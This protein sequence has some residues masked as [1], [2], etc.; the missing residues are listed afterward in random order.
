MKSHL[1]FFTSSLGLLSVSWF[2]MAATIRQAAAIELDFM[3]TEEQ[4]TENSGTKINDTIDMFYNEEKDCQSGV[5]R[6]NKNYT[7]IGSENYSQKN[8]WLKFYVGFDVNWYVKR[9]GGNIS[10]LLRNAPTIHS[11]NFW[12]RWQDFDLYG[13]VRLLRFLGAEVGYTHFGNVVAK[14][15]KKTNLDG[16]FASALLYTP[17]FNLFDLFSL[18]SYVSAGGTMLFDTTNGGKP[19][20]GLRCGTGVIAKVYGTIAVNAGVDYYYPSGSFS[21]KGFLT[22]KTGINIYLSI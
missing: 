12:R 13:G 1:R 3:D 14:D 22:V 19:F 7:K 11:T 8:K 6:N 10:S 2:L 15:G 20:F 21:K 9:F 16:A 5:C 17:H 18:E 4:K